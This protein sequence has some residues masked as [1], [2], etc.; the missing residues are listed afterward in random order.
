M[1]L[2][3]L[4]YFVAVAEELHFGR[5]AARLY[6]SQPALSFDIK[7]LEGQLDVQ[8]LNRN[9]K[10]VNLT[11]AG[12]VLLEEARYLLLRAEQAKRLTSLS[13]QGYTGR[14]SIGFLNSILNRGLPRAVKIF[15]ADHPETEI[16]LMEMNSAEQAQAL[17][18]G[19]I[20][21]GF[22]HWNTVSDSV[23]CEP[24][25]SEPFLCCLPSGHRLAGQPRI[26]LAALAQDDFIL[27]PRSVSPHYHDRIIAQCVAAGFSPRIRHETR[28]WQTVVTM[29]AHEMGVALVPETLA[30]AWNEGVHYCEIDGVSALSDVHAIRL[31]AKD[32]VAAQSFLDLFKGLQQTPQ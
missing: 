23:R 28:L 21:I 31:A 32:S 17:Q 7:K 27:F 25:F 8:L 22:V 10:S 26:A 16:V 12:Q 6:I 3:Q 4:R 13:A 24:V 18:R 2:K 15:E 29:V 5:A 30:Q 1:D 20:D 11:N 9:N 14:L 19:Q